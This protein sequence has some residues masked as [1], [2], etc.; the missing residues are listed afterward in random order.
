MWVFFTVWIIIDI[1][2]DVAEKTDYIY[3]DSLLH[4]PTT[5]KNLV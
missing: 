2:L 4:A 1:S 3:V 5:L